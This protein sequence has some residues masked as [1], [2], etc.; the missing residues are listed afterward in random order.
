MARENQGLQIALIIFV[1][2]TL[3][4]GVTSFLFFKQ[5]ED[6]KIQAKTN[7]QR[8]T[9]QE[10]KARAAVEENQ[11]LKQMMGFAV[12]EDETAISTQF[13]QDMQTYAANFPEDI[14][15]YRQVLARLYEILQS[16]QSDLVAA[17]T[18]LEQQKARFAAHQQSIE[19][20]IK[21][22]EQRA[23]QIA[24]EMANERAKFKQD[25]AQIVADKNALAQQL[26]EARK[27]STAAVAQVQQKLQTASQEV[28]KLTQLLRKKT[29]QLEAVTA[30]TVEVPD[31]EI[32]WVN[33]REGTVWI[34]LGRADGLRR[35]VT[36]SVYPADLTNLS[37]AVKKGS[38]E[39]TRILGDHV[40]EARIVEDKISDPL[41]PGDK[42][43]TPLWNAGE[44]L[45][46]ALA[47][48]ID[49]D[50]DSRSD[51]DEIRRLITM[52]GG[53]IDCE[54]DP[55]TGERIGRITV[56]TRYLVV[57]EAPKENPQFLDSWSKMIGDAQR[58]GVRQ[59]SVA[60]LLQR[61]GWKPRTRAVSY[62]PDMNPEDFRPKPPEGGQRVS[63]GNV[64][65]LFRPRTP[66]RP[67]RGGAY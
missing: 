61:M 38:I 6:A 21:Q 39:V 57:G 14:H 25:Y 1:M 10:S 12:T 7:L 13:A 4:L 41:M 11:K 29:E 2:L 27:Q 62:G 28:I 42:I 18:E 32:R 54:M 22:H 43:H 49:I 8:A 5:A 50:N 46:F 47:G 53:V 51:Q 37:E 65:G 33:Q 63:T 48:F 15:N 44:Q 24:Q 66:P 60:E 30:E 58:L 23:Q 45:R 64:S 35:Q 17:R 59:I 26:Q 36:F 16:T 56:N 40:A 19:P 31:G 3:I 55:K 67:N 9:E 52:N 20:Q 34:N